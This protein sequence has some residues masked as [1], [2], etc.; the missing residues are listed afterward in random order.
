V[1]AGVVEGAVVRV[2]AMSP[3]V[4]PGPRRRRG[5]GLHRPRAHADAGALPVHGIAL[6]AL[7]A[8]IPE[9]VAARALRVAC[10]DTIE[11]DHAH[12]VR[13]VRRRIT[14]PRLAVA[15]ALHHHSAPRSAVGSVPVQAE[16]C[17]VVLTALAAFRA[18][19][20]HDQAFQTIRAQIA[21]CGIPGKDAEDH[22]HRDHDDEGDPADGPLP[23]LRK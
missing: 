3:V 4:L 18:G 7:L 1:A 14:R 2:A 16:R 9:T 21:W 5:I 12:V 8:V 19:L 20:T 13:T 23:E 17:S 10:L 15:A 6:V 22:R 11:R